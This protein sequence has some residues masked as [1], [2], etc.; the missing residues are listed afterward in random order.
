MLTQTQQKA[1]IMESGTLIS[2]RINQI[3]RGQEMGEHRR[4]DRLGFY[5]ELDVGPCLLVSRELGAGG[6][7]I[8]SQLAQRLGWAHMDKEII[9]K[10]ASQYG[11]PRVVLDAVDEKKVGWLVDLF[12]G[13]IEGHGFSQLSYVNRLG[14]L[15]NMMAKRGNV[16]IVGRGAKFLLP[17]GAGFSVRIIAPMEFRVEQLVLR[18]AV[19]AEKAR[20]LIQKS[21]TDRKSFIKTYFHH[22]VTD[23][24]VHD[25]VVN[26]KQVTPAFAVQMIFDAVQFWLKRSGFLAGYHNRL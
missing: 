17:K 12:N 8:A 2:D 18:R 13:W 24:H 22:D 26:I 21:D 23:P 11:T 20:S 14:R 5:D 15:F 10:L 3:R 1:C 25:L 7:Q 9:E 6:G 16:V 19:T 4:N